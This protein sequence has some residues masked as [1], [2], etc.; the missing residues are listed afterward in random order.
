MNAIFMFIVLVYVQFPVVSLVSV[1]YWLMD[2]YK[3]IFSYYMKSRLVEFKYWNYS[4]PHRVLIAH[5]HSRCREYE[6]T[7]SNRRQRK[8]PERERERQRQ[9][10]SLN[11]PTNENNQNADKKFKCRLGTRREFNL[12]RVDFGRCQLLCTYLRLART[13]VL[14]NHL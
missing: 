7:S 2:I 12:K 4:R 6:W 11:S 10:T 1:R 5:W 9:L 8:H 3:Q 14:Q 13:K